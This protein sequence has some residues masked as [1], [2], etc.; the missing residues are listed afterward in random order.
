MRMT[1]TRTMW[2]FIEQITVKNSEYNHFLYES[3]VL[4]VAELHDKDLNN[5]KNKLLV[6]IDTKRLEEVR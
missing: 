3:R 6:L 1:K 4:D 2:H 5:L